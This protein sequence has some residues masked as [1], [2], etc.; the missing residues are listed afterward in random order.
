MTEQ[1]PQMTDML[2]DIEGVSLPSAY[3]FALWEALIEHAP[4][5]AEEYSVGVLPL[6]GTANRDGLLLSK[7]AKLA[8]RLPDAQA[9][10]IAARLAGRDLDISGRRIRL[11]AAKARPIFPFPTVHAELVTGAKDEVL[12][13]QQ[14][15]EQL[16]EMGIKGKLICGRRRN[17]GDENQSIQGYSLVIHDLK[18]EASLQLQFAGLGTDR[19][20]GCGIFVPSKVISGLSED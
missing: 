13:V 4:E 7:R 17:I 5:L 16:G 19:R 18:A 6:R 12:F 20:F 11:G 10:Q 2:F 3:P 1:I 15:N 8:V 9:D 14:I